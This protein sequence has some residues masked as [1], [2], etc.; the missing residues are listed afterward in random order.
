MRAFIGRRGALTLTGPLAANGRVRGE[1]LGVPFTGKADH[2]RRYIIVEL[3]EPLQEIRADLKVLY[4]QSGKHIFDPVLARTAGATVT[5]I[6]DQV[7]DT[8]VEPAGE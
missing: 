5:R 3:D 6:E 1:Y 8:W 2:H 7:R 4:I